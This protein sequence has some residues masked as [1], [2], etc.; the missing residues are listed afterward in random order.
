MDNDVSNFGKENGLIHEAVVTGRNVGAG[1][2][3]WS[4]LAHDSQ[5]FA[6]LVAVVEGKACIR[7]LNHV[8]D[9]KTKPGL[10]NGEYR[11][12]THISHGQ[13]KW[14]PAKVLLVPKD[15]EVYTGTPLNRNVLDYLEQFPYLIPPSWT[16]K[17]VFFM[18]TRFT[19]GSGSDRVC[20][21]E[22]SSRGTPIVSIS[23]DVPDP[24]REE[25]H[26]IAVLT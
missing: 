6:Q 17:R 22:V 20:S 23:P 13:L 21:M 11:V 9:T 10:L 5:F 2:D 26:Y 1:S 25:T 18:G 14:D 19:S 3:F 24:C 12:K 7:H 8:I 15:Q 16:G 4:K